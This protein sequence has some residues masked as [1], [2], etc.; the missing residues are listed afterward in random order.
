MDRA[1]REFL[2]GHTS[3]GVCSAQRD[4]DGIFP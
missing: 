3:K 1:V 4:M 2:T